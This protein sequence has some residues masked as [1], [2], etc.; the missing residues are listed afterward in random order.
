MDDTETLRKVY[1]V[2]GGNYWIQSSGWDVEQDHCDWYGISCDDDGY[3][4]GIDD[5]YVANCFN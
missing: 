2:T 5:I 3:V 4:T 1:D